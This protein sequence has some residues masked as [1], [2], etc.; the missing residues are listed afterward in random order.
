MGFPYVEVNEAGDFII[1]KA[2]E[3]GGVVSVDTCK[4]QAI[5]KIHN[6]KYYMTPDAIADFSQ[7]NFKQIK[8]NV[9][10]ASGAATHGKPN[11]LKVD[12]IGWNSLYKDCIAEKLGNENMPIEIRMRALEIV[13]VYSIFIPAGSVSAEEFKRNQEW[14]D[15]EHGRIKENGY[16]GRRRKN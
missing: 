5:Y 6:P 16:W 13:S 11:E 7:V 10:C 15:G 3:T 4:E 9:V 12:F 2:E 8:E 1:S 14:E